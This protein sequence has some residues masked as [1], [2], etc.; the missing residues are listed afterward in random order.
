ML[1]FSKIKISKTPV[2][3]LSD[4]QTGGG[5]LSCASRLSRPPQGEDLRLGHRL[6]SQVSSD[7]ERAGRKTRVRVRAACMLA[8]L[9]LACSEACS[10][11]SLPFLSHRPGP[12]TR[13]QGPQGSI[14]GG[15]PTEACGKPAHTARVCPCLSGCGNC[16]RGKS[17]APARAGGKRGTHR[18]RE[19]EGKHRAS[20][21]LCRS[22]PVLQIPRRPKGSPGGVCAVRDV[23]RRRFVALLSSWA[24][25]ARSALTPHTFLSHSLS[26]SLPCVPCR[27]RLDSGPHLPPP[28]CTFSRPSATGTLIPSTTA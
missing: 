2:S 28:E 6:L 18:R 8:C 12:A 22:K 25:R 11:Q 5:L 17:F 21:H 4:A 10:C 15:E 1:P 20:C 13:S 16:R 26:G 27:L 9:L 7:S 19:A 24:S 14:R 23:H 3:S